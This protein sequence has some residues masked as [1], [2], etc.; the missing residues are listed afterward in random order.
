M[1]KSLP[2]PPS[3]PPFPPTGLCK[4]QGT[5]QSLVWEPEQSCSGLAPCKLHGQPR[6][7]HRA[8][9]TEGTTRKCFP[10]VRQSSH[11]KLGQ[12]SL[13]VVWFFCML[14]TFYEISH[15]F[16]PLKKFLDCEA[17]TP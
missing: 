10:P 9:H 6:H 5:T 17:V 1:F 4:T 8:G 13:L 11:H 12:L 16:K 14:V 2:I 7:S 3:P 15:L